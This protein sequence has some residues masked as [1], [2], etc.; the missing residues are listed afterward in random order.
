LLQKGLSEE[1]ADEVI[2]AFESKEDPEDSLQLLEKALSDE[3]I[4]EPLSKAKKDNFQKEDKKEDKKSG[5]DDDDKDYNAEYMKKY[6][7]RYMK[8][9]K[10]ACGKMA[11][12]VGIYA[13]EMKK[14]IDDVDTDLDGAVIEM[15]DLKPVFEKLPEVISSMAKAI[16]EISGQ[17]IA[18]TS[19]NEQTFDVMKKA[20][21][22]TVETA[23]SMNDFLG[24]PTGKKGKVAIPG[25]DMKKASDA[26]FTPEAKR[27]I[28]SKLMKATREGDRTA[29][30]VISAFDSAGQDLNK[31]NP[32][33]RK[34][35]SELMTKEVH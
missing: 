4:E 18:V 30:A 28:Y 15:A 11:K 20:A 13:E 33:H 9:N 31:L 32:G 27:E 35:I 21:T 12:E 23:K 22:V 1:V 24:Q 25:E 10:K 19:Q 17:V 5:D 16:E 26:V 8:E 34:Y 14:A 2:T 3:P 29:G 7:K 6:M